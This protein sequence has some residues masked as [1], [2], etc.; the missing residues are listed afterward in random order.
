MTVPVCVW[1]RSLRP[2]LFRD[3]VSRLERNVIKPQPR[4]N[5]FWAL[6]ERSLE[7]RA[8]NA[9]KAVEFSDAPEEFKGT[10]PPA[11]PSGEGAEEGGRV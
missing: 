3:A 4:I 1:Q 9:Q 11:G 10:P 8:R 5:A 7:I 6:A 2:E